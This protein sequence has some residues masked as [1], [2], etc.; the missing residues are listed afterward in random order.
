M[1]DSAIESSRPDPLSLPEEI[2]RQGCQPAVSLR[3]A[4]TWDHPAV[5]CRATKKRGMFI[6]TPVVAKRL[7]AV[8]WVGRRAPLLAMAQRESFIVLSNVAL[9]AKLL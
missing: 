5:P 1:L 8:I 7:E 2:H 4:I 6:P 3:K 9:L